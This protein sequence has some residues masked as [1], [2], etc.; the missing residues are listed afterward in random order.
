MK[1]KHLPPTIS[2]LYYFD[3]DSNFKPYVGAGIN[4]TFFFED[5]FNPS[6]SGDSSPVIQSISDG[7]TVTAIG[8]PL[9]AGD[10]NLEN[11]WGLSAQVGFDY[12]IDKNWS[13]NMSARY[14]DI[15]TTARFTAVGG[16]VP[17]QVDVEIDP[18]VYSLQVGYKF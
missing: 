16:T 3:T 2:A 9:D 11:S 5:K 1:T 15:D 6:M 12:V 7:T 13:V 8:A 17:G 4:Y 14:I 18:M 10:L